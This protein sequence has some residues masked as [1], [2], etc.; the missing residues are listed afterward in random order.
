MLGFGKKKEQKK[1][2]NLDKI[3]M[4]VIVGGAIGSVLG[5]GLAPGKGSETRKEVGRQTGK[6]LHGARK[7]FGKAAARL[8]GRKRRQ[9]DK[10]VRMGVRQANDAKYAGKSI[11]EEK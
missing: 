3:L 6:A 9:E 2:G 8:L 10:P 11:P 1:Q 5:V 7:L 4:G